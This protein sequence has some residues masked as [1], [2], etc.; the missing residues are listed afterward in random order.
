MYTIKQTH[1]LAVQYRDALIAG[2]RDQAVDDLI[3]AVDNGLSVPRLY[4]EVLQPAQHSI[5]DL[6]QSNSI[7]V[8]VEHYCTA[9][10]QLL[11]A[12]LF[13][14]VMGDGSAG[15]T[16]VGCC[17]SGD[18][19]ELGVRMVCDFFEMANWTTHFL[20]S[21]MPEADLLSFAWDNKSDLIC[22]SCTTTFNV[23]RVKRIIDMA[24]SEFGTKRPPILVGGIPFTMA[25]DLV[26]Q[27]GAD[28]TAATAKDAVAIGTALVQ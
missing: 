21:S 2:K 23:H 1:E 11:M 18:L 28:A 14:R 9:V 13:P 6:W 4:M 12:Q 19:H 5:G 27:V 22:I 16:L 7:S 24:K 3:K 10:T 26:S 17:V 25:P 8:A 20:G 15:K